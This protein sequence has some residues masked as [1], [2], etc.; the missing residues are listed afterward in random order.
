MYWSCK[1]WQWASVDSVQST[2]NFAK[3]NVNTDTTL[4]VIVIYNGCAVNRPLILH[5]VF[6]GV[7]RECYGQW[8][9]HVFQHFQ[10]FPTISWRTKSES[11]TL[12]RWK[13]WQRLTAAGQLKVGHWIA[14][15]SPPLK[16]LWCSALIGVQMSLSKLSSAISLYWISCGYWFNL[17]EIQSIPQRGWKPAQCR[18]DPTP[19]FCAISLV[20]SSCHNSTLSPLGWLQTSTRHSTVLILPHGAQCNEW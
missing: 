9:Q 4:Y 20:L 16:H 1:C 15:S 18:A 2:S 14:E 13:W 6:V 8:Q 5:F 3:A 17:R 19:L 12:M 11:W 10:Q 7:Q